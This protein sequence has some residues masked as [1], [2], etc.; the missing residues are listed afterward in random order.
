LEKL[1]REQE[2]IRT[3]VEEKLKAFEKRKPDEIAQRE[4]SDKLREAAKKQNE[5]AE[6]LAGLD[7]PGL[8]RR[9]ERVA[10]SAKRAADDLRDGLPQDIPASQ[11]DLRRRMSQLRTAMEGGTPSDAIADEL[12]RKQNALAEKL[13]QEKPNLAELQKLQSEIAGGTSSL[14]DPDAA[15]RLAKAKQST[16]SAAKQFQQADDVDELRKKAKQA[17]KDLDELADQLSGVET[18]RERIERLAKQRR[19]RADWSKANAGKPTPAEEAAAIQGELDRELS[20]LK[21]TRSGKAQESKKAAVDQLERLKRTPNSER[22]PA[23]QQAA[24]DALDELAKKMKRE[25]LQ[26]PRGE[27]QP[28][29]GDTSGDANGQLASRKDADAAKKLAQQQR[30]L[31]DATAQASGQAKPDEKTAADQAMEQKKLEEKANEL[32]HK[33]DSASHGTTTGEGNASN[34]TQAAE[35]AK[36]AKEAMEKAGREQEKGRN[37]SAA[38]ARQEAAKALDQAKAKADAA[39]GNAG[40]A[41]DPKAAEASKSAEEAN[42]LL[43]QAGEATGQNDA[44]KSLKKASE[45]IGDAADKL[46]EAGNKQSNPNSPNPGGQKGGDKPLTA[47]ELPPDLKQYAGT[48]WGELPGDVKARVIQDLKA[49]YG[50]DYARVIKLY[51]EQLAEKK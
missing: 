38:E 20:D 47:E 2:A 46:G 3:E 48:P 1:Q 29:D 44:A 22:A 35:A 21:Q 43:R 10:E 39:A 17:A 15:L 36:K 28:K 16:D 7:T 8:D 5:L 41:S 23:V 51:F 25:D 14:N 31:R 34:L 26:P 45:K 9:L 49:K 6:K 13:A 32:Y 18:D 12:A 40:A 4:I 30:E 27:R 42:N 50:E 37:A 11:E 33:L 24:A 19:A